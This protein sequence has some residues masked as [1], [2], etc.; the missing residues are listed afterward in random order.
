MARA[1]RAGGTSVDSALSIQ[2]TAQGNVVTAPS[3]CRQF[4]TIV[5]ET[6]LKKLR[7]CQQMPAWYTN[8]HRELLRTVG[9][10][11]FFELVELLRQ[12]SDLTLL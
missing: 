7:G 1:G 9:L 12:C 10:V 8:T 4:A 5:V 6:D 2:T 3:G 11:E